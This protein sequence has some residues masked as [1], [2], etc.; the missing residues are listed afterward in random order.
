VGGE[1][2]K[3]ISAVNK[4]LTRGRRLGGGKKPRE[5]GSAPIEKKEGGGLIQVNGGSE[6]GKKNTENRLKNELGTLLPHRG[7]QKKIPTHNFARKR[8]GEE[9]EDWNFTQ[10][11]TKGM[12]LTRNHGAG[13]GEGGGGKRGN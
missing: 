13:T 2:G 11:R 6:E 9:G 5:V 12:T 3:N 8:R 10:G 1:W 4:S 7:G